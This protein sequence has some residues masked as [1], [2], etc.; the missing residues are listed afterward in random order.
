VEDLEDENRELKAQVCTCDK[1][2]ARVAQKEESD[3]GL[4]YA[5]PEEAE[6]RLPVPITVLPAVSGQRCKPSKGHLISR[7][8]FPSISPTGSGPART[9]TIICNKRM[10]FSQVVS[11]LQST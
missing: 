3:N 11:G 7:I 1:Y 5:T 9:T 6:I 10:E 4:S 2:E 8:A